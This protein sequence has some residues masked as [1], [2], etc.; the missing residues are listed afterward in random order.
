ME[1]KPVVQAVVQVR[2]HGKAHAG[3]QDRVG[4]AELHEREETRYLS[5]V[6]SPPT[7]RK[8]P[9]ARDR[10]LIGCSGIG[11]HSSKG[12]AAPVP[13]AKGSWPR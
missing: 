6:L 5:K 1:G 12:L 9:N 13:T 11:V 4:A 2:A 10:G 3:G 7:T 8:I